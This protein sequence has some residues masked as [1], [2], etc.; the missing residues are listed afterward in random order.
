VTT[1]GLAVGAHQHREQTTRLIEGSGGGATEGAVISHRSPLEPMFGRCSA[2]RGHLSAVCQQRSHTR[3]Y[4]A[5]RCP[6]L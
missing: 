5:L 2:V 4:V 1:G 3:P 6:V